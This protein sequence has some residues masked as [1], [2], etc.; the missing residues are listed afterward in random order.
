MKKQLLVTTLAGAFALSGAV[1]GSGDHDHSH[2]E[3]HKGMTQSGHDEKGGAHNKTDMFLKQRA[4]DGYQ[5][6]FH[7]MRAKSGMEHGGS[8]NLMVKVEQGDKVLNDVIINSKVVYPDGGADIK[9]L[10]K[11]GDWYMNGYDLGEQGKHQLL[12]LFETADGAK[13]KSGVYYSVE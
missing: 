2:D 11:M 4:V 6:S 10:M 5:I 9:P 1:Y 7:V 12:I 13:H 3:E 8:H